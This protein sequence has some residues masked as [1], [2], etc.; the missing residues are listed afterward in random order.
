VRDA[1]PELAQL[2]D[3]AEL[4]RRA[5]LRRVEDRDRLLVGAA[6]VRL[7]VAHRL[8]CSPLDVRLDRTCDCG[9]PHGKPRV[10]TPAPV[11]IS[12]S[13]AGAAV[14][15]AVS[16][17]PAVGV[18]VERVDPTLDRTSLVDEVLSDVEQAR[19]A[20]APLSAAEFFAVWTRKEAVLKATGDGL[21][22]PLGDLTLGAAPL[23]LT[24][25]R[26]RGDMVH[27]VSLVD[28]EP[29]AGHAASLATLGGGPIEV[30]ALDGS[31]L[32]QAYA[33]SD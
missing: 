26:G 27:R 12:I 2:L 16:D 30:Q 13:H 4:D 11:E 8:G 10:T 22:V 9:E 17:G 21:R 25:W 24:G 28:L 20:G 7:A 23:R 33:P 18:D 3:R 31:V 15:V 14:V 32:L 6:L 19:L 1:R 5:R 29:P